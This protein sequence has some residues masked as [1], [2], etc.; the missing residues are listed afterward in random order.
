LHGNVILEI[1]LNYGLFVLSEG[2]RPLSDLFL[3][4]Q[5]NLEFGIFAR[6][7]F[8]NLSGL[9]IGADLNSGRMINDDAII[10]VVRTFKRLGIVLVLDATVVSYGFFFL[11]NMGYV[12]R[13][14]TISIM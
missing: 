9:L 10:L 11:A 14:N 6:R 4:H 5:H 7:V 2:I 3:S 12:L 1:D 8:P 13:P